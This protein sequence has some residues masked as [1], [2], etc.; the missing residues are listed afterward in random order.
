MVDFL[1]VEEGLGEG[2]PVVGEGAAVV[3]EGAL[4]VLGGGGLG[5]PLEESMFFLIQ[6][7]NLV[8]LA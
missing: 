3:G 2:A 5:V 1:V 6:S 8:T 4:V 7:I